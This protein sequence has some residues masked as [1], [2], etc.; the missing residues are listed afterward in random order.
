MKHFAL[1]CV[2]LL[3]LVGCQQKKEKSKDS[4]ATST[5]E[6]TSKKDLSLLEEIAYANGYDN[7]S[8][9]DSISYTFNA[10]NGD[11]ISSRTWKWK[12][13]T[14]QVTMKTQDTTLTYNTNK[15]E[16][17]IAFA[18]RGFV[19]DK[20]WLLFPF[21][22]V[23]DDNFDYEVA[24]QVKAPISDE[25]MQEIS[26]MYK[27]KA[28]YTPGD[29]YHVYVDDTNMIREWSYTPSGSDEPRLATTWEDYDDFKGIKIARMH[30]T[31]EG[32]FKIFF[33]D[34]SVN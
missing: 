1:L 30:D 9:V 3:I 23:W 10:Q 33:T 2:S 22:L 25:L 27:N 17:E 28:G 29:T 11:N 32:Q 8:E 18:D 16:E 31:K 12:P 14:G 5:S 20:Y 15:F 13:K 34:I 24:E 7:W 4:K 26:V 19:N 21:H 6:V